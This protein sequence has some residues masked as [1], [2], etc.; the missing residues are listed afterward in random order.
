[1]RSTDVMTQCFTCINLT[2]CATRLG[3]S[4]ST[5]SGRPVATAQKEHERVQIFPNIINVAVPAPQHSPILGQFPLSHIVCSLCSSARL[6]TWRYSLPT[7]SVTR[8][9]SGLRCVSVAGITGSSIM[10]QSYTLFS[11]KI[12]LSYVTVIPCFFR[13]IPIADKMAAHTLQKKLVF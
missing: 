11:S 3:S 6:R 5:A 2:D 12:A 10:S 8:N 13:R 7:G 4:K 1:S 9:Q